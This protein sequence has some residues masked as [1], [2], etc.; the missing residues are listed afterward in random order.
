MHLKS[1]DKCPYS[2]QNSKRQRVEGHMKTEI[3]A[4]QPQAK[5]HV[6]RKE[7]GRGEEGF[8]PGAL[9]E[10]SPANILIWFFWPP[11]L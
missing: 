2:R 10:H 8:S 5:E 1:N 4:M 3:G 7:A 11:E 6:E 9:R